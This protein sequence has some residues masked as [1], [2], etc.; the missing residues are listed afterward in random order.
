[1]LDLCLLKYLLLNLFYSHLAMVGGVLTKNVW[2][3]S[4]K[5]SFSLGGEHG[6]RAFASCSLQTASLY[7]GEWNKRQYYL[8]F[9]RLL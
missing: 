9:A 1:M 2:I 7:Y 8:C 5:V 3:G 4:G 6:M